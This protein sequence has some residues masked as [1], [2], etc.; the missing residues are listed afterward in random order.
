MIILA[1]DHFICDQLELAAGYEW[2]N[3]YSTNYPENYDTYENC[4]LQIHSSTEA[5]VVLEIVEFITERG[6][7]KVLVY[8]GSNDQ[9]ELLATLTGNLASRVI[10]STGPFLYL[11]YTTDSSSVRKGFHM[12]FKDNG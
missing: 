7:D 10:E 4:E 2:H 12:K 11:R 3:L 1:S 5:T 8:D 9:A 6:Y